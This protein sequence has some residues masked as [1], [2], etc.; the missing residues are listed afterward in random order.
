MS[1][2]VKKC[3]DVVLCVSLVFFMM[4]SSSFAKDEKISVKETGVYVKTNKGLKRLLPN[5][6]FTNENGVYYTEPN[7]P[8]H[9][10]LKDLDS[11]VFYGTYN[12][13]YLTFNPMTPLDVSSLGKPSFM[14]GR[15]I[16]IDLKKIGADLYTVRPK[17]LLG[18]G[19]H[20][21]WINDTA[22]DFILD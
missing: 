21:F 2:Y 17:R 3:L 12:F 5:I 7:N 13:Q 1:N 11:F 15:D 16:E 6:V 9:F 14:F 22:W 8:P 20:S 4:A 19:Y 18:R 10:L